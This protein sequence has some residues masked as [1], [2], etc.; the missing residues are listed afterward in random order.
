MPDTDKLGG[1]IS[2]ESSTRTP[3]SCRSQSGGTSQLAVTALEHDGCV[4]TITSQLAG[5]VSSGN[6]SQAT[7]FT[8]IV[9]GGPL[10][11]SMWEA[12]SWLAC[13]QNHATAVNLVVNAIASDVD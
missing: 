10:D 1:I 3:V 7:A 9:Y 5:I 11:A 2:T 12:K 4:V 13:L 8:T 6:P